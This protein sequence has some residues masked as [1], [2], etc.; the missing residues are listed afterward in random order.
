MLFILETRKAERTAQAALRIATALVN[1]RVLSEREALIS[2]DSNL[3]SR[4]VFPMLDPR[5]GMFKYDTTT[6]S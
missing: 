4:F 5:F 2:I 3:I 1:E 6:M